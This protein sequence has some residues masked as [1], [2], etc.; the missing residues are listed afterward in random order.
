M[1]KAWKWN[2]HC[3]HD[4][5]CSSVCCDQKSLKSIVLLYKS[6][7]VLLWFSITSFAFSKNKNKS[8]QL[9]SILLQLFSILLFVFHVCQTQI[10][11][12][13][14]LTFYCVLVL[15]VLSFNI[16]WQMFT[17]VYHI[18]VCFSCLPPSRFQSL[19][20]NTII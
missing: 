18:V 11:D 20:T 19:K 7:N 9:F 1:L 4:T 16:K 12:G 8:L 15:N 14:Y 10:S 3:K 6:F 2:R 17:T 13:N 5:T